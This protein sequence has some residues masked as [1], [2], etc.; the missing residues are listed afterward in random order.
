M[1]PWIGKEKAD[2]IFDDSEGEFTKLLIERGYLESDAWMDQQPTYFCEV[3]T[4]TRDCEERFYV[5]GA[6]Y[7]LVSLPR[8]TNGRFY[9]G[10]NGDMFLDAAEKT[11]T[12]KSGAR[13]L[14]P[15]QSL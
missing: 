1:K 10:A 8:T 3:K 4:T 7:R 2:I 6:Q 9:N 11:P 12:W 15:V 13:D 14:C 5:S